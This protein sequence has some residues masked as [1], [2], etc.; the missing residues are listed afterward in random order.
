MVERGLY[1]EM[2]DN[3]TY[4]A[5]TAIAGAGTQTLFTEAN[6][7]ETRGAIRVICLLDGITFGAGVT[8]TLRLQRQIAAAWGNYVDMQILATDDIAINQNNEAV[9]YFDAAIDPAVVTSFRI[10]LVTVGAGA[11]VTATA[12]YCRL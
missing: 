6:T 10:Q 9:V 7:A 1:Q 5:A 11:A 3:E 4:G 8:Y 2:I 12:G